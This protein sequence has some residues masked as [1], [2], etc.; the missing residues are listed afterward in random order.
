MEKK[1]Y[2]NEETYQKTK[3]K[4]SKIAIIVLIVGILIGGSLIATGLIK[5]SKVNSQYSEESKAALASQL[6]T[7]K[8]DI[9]SQIETEK[10][11]LIK[12]KSDIESQIKP[13]EDEIKK[14]ERTPFTG[15]DDAYYARQDKIEELEESIKTEKNSISVIDDALD[16]SF[17]HCNFDEAK[18][19]VY[20]SKYCSLKK[21]L[22]EKTA[23][24]NN[25]DNQFSDFKKNF[26][27]H[28]NVPFYMFGAFIIVASGMIAFAIF[29]FTKQRE[30]LSFTTQQVMPVAKE[31]IEEIAPT[32]GKAG[33]SIAKEIVPTIGKAGASIAKE[34]APVYGDIAKEISKGIKEGIKDDKE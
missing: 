16:E 26:D 24:I 19:N 18:N 14:L 11:N 21:Q 13:T 25:L 3:K 27:S 5:Q 31:G 17:N 15:F 10:Q 8:Q 33:A 34:M 6:E 20:T 7:E 1:K 2:L 4:I 23:E 28:D 22:N 30:I 32:I 29:M 9:S 12:S